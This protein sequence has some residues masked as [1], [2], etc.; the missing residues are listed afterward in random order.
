MRLKLHY[1]SVPHRWFDITHVDP[2]RSY[3]E[4]E[5]IYPKIA[6]QLTEPSVGIEEIHCMQFDNK[7]DDGLN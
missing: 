5:R 6:V 4:P 7:V 2:S 1:I 3:Q